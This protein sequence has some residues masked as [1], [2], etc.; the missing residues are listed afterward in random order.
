MTQERIGRLQ[1]IHTATGELQVAHSS[2]PE[3]MTGSRF[4]WLFLLFC[5]AA[6]LSAQQRVHTEPAVRMTPAFVEAGSPELITVSAPAAKSMEGEW[7]GHKLEFFH[8]G[9]TW[10][11]LAGVDV[12]AKPESSTL[13]L[14][15]NTATGPREFSRTIE[16]HPAH[17]RTGKLTVA[18][19]F[20]EPGPE[21]QKEVAA[22]AEIKAKLI[23]ASATEPLWQGSF[24]AP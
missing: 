16:I 14:T 12:E 20:V 13:H 8:H 3:R 22:D 7:L 2:Y 17:Y 21:E 5:L 24:R 9:D 23:A 18:P 15:A 19:K 1:E 11:S 6:T 10:I 4:R